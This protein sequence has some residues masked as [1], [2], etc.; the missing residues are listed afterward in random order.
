MTQ[1]SAA[2]GDPKSARERVLAYADRFRE[3]MGR[4]PAT[5]VVFAEDF[6]AL[7]LRHFRRMP[8][9]VVRGPSVQEYQWRSP[10]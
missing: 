9:R 2:I 7:D 3:F 5:V 4:L 8:Y 1:R 6:D 10:S